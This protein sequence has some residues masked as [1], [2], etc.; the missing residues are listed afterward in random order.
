MKNCQGWRLI[1]NTDSM[2]VHEH[3]QLIV[4]DTV[5]ILL[6]ATAIKRLQHVKN[7]YRAA[8][9]ALTKRIKSKDS[10]DEEKNNEVIIPKEQNEVVCKNESSL[11]EN[12][13][14][15]VC[16]TLFPPRGKKSWKP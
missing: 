9:H 12:E 1:V 10:D 3:A 7:E 8:D 16:S 5:A 4:Q 13:L 15:I 11:N 6:E 14:R 2:P